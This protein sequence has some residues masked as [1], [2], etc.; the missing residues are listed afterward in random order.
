MGVVKNNTTGMAIDGAKVTAKVGRATYTTTQTTD[1]YVLSNLPLT[2]YNVTA[3]A[4]GYTAQTKSVTLFSGTPNLSVE[5]NFD[6]VKKG[7]K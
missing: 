2:T 3:S 1:N 7:K 6:L 4:S 5:V